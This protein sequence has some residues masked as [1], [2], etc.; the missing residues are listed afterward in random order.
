MMRLRSP[1]CA[2]HT[3][4]STSP[5]RPVISSLSSPG[6]SRSSRSIAF[7]SSNTNRAISNV[8][9]CSR[10]FRFAFRSSHSNASS[11]MIY[12]YAVLRQSRKFRRILARLQPNPRTSDQ[13]YCRSRAA[14]TQGKLSAKLVWEMRDAGRSGPS[15]RAQKRAGGTQCIARAPGCETGRNRRSATGMS[16]NPRD[17][18]YRKRARDGRVEPRLLER[19]VAHAG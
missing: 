10:S 11:R 14:S 3:V 2:K 18:A 5:T 9:P 7:G 17:P 6:S 8:T 16:R 4:K 12:W 1:R 13:R 19:R 15:V